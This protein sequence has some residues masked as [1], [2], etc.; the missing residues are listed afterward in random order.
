MEVGQFLAIKRPCGWD[1]DSGQ[2]RNLT[3][4]CRHTHRMLSVYWSGDAGYTIEILAESMGNRPRRRSLS[5]AIIQGRI[6]SPARRTLTD[7]RP[8]RF[9]IMRLDRR[10]QY[11][12]LQRL[13]HQ[14][15]EP[16]H[17]FGRN[18]DPL[19]PFGAS[20]QEV[21]RHPLAANR[22][23]AAAAAPQSVL[24]RD[25]GDAEMPRGFARV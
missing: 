6:F 11:R 25:H 17:L 9:M 2:K 19:L 15:I 24:E 18:A 5:V 21:D 1:Q 12:N 7:C 16:I 13:H 10:E 22:Q 23:Q 20:F 8:E 14:L 3:Y 4:I